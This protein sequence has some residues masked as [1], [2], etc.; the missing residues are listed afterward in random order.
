MS[1]NA[2]IEKAVKALLNAGG[3]PERKYPTP[4]NKA[5]LKEVKC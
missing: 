3:L 2:Q 5:I 4:N 1:K